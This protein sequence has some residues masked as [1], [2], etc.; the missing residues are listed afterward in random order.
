M[1][2]NQKKWMV[3]VLLGAKMSRVQKELVVRSSISLANLPNPM[4]YT[5][6][7]PTH[8]TLKNFKLTVQLS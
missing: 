1:V 3:L 6:R 8:P 7:N 5:L 4:K 2:M